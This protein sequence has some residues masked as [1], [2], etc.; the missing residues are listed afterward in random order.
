MD[1]CLY[2]RNTHYSYWEQTDRLDWILFLAI[3]R[4]IV[5]GTLYASRLCMVRL[6]GQ[7]WVMLVIFIHLKSLWPLNC[8]SFQPLTSPQLSSSKAAVNFFFLIN[9]YIFLFQSVIFLEDPEVKSWI[10]FGQRI[11]LCELVQYNHQLY[12]TLWLCDSQ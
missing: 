2:H 7:I 6:F 9:I 4:S 5:M 1:R 8:A 10:C 12:V 3:I 11:C